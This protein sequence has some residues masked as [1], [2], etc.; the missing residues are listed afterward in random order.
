MNFELL[1]HIHNGLSSPVDHQHAHVFKRNKQKAS[2]YLVGGVYSFALKIKM[3]LSQLSLK[4]IEIMLKL[5]IKD[6]EFRHVIALQ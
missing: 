3:A 4:L 6:L 1:P 2:K 5:D